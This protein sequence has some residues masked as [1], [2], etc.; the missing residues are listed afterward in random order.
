MGVPSAIATEAVILCLGAAVG[1][2]LVTCY[3]RVEELAPAGRVTGAMTVAS[4]GNVL[5]VSLGSLVTGAIGGD[6]HLGNLPAAVAGACMVVVALGE[7]GRAGLR[8]RG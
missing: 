1:M 3:S 6:L 4:T 7:A 5:G 8:R 2:T